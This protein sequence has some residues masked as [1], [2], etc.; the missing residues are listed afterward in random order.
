MSESKANEVL[1]RSASSTISALTQKCFGVIQGL[2]GGHLAL[3]VSVTHGMYE[4][5]KVHNNQH[6]ARNIEASIR[7]AEAA[8]LAEQN[9]PAT[10]A[11]D[12]DTAAP[13]LKPDTETSGK[14]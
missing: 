1:V 7:A 10:P 5:A 14:A 3:I 12:N 4:I 8:M 6:I 13:A 9:M 11:A 2:C